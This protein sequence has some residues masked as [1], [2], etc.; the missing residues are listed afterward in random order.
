MMLNLNDSRKKRMI[1][2]GIAI[3]LVGAMVLSL[4]IA[5]IV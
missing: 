5:A 2:G 3:L 4:L 1:A